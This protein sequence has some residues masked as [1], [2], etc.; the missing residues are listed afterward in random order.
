MK[1]KK[2]KRIRSSPHF[3][4]SLLPF[5]H[6]QLSTFPFT[7]YLLSFSIF[8]LFNFFLASFFPEGQQKFPGQKSLGAT[9]HPRLL[10]HWLNVEEVKFTIMYVYILA[11]FKHLTNIVTCTLLFCDYV[12]YLLALWKF[13]KTDF[14]H[15]RVG[16]KYTTFSSLRHEP[17]AS[18]ICLRYAPTCSCIQLYT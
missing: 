11:K 9:L 4:T 5:F 14:K 7:I 6:F 17:L 15:N 2:K 13:Q 18:N 16:K 3:G 1:R 8:P 10:R 12:T